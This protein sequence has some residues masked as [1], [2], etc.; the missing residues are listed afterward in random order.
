MKAVLARNTKQAQKFLADRSVR[1]VIG[2]YGLRRVYVLT[3]HR[4]TAERIANEF[5]GWTRTT[6]TTE[7]FTPGKTVSEVVAMLVPWFPEINSWLKN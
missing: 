6:G 5:I 2:S 3:R 4:E 7:V 1:I